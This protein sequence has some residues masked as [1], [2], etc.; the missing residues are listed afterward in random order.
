VHVLYVSQENMS[1]AHTIFWAVEE[2]DIDSSVFFQELNRFL[3]DAT[4]LF[5][6]GTSIAEDVSNILMRFSQG[7]PYIP[8][9]GSYG[10]ILGDDDSQ[11]FRCSFD[12]ELLTEL[13]R[14]SYIHAEPEICDH[15]MI[16]HDEELIMEYYDFPKNEIAFNGS[17]PE[18]KIRAFADALQCTYKK[19]QE[20]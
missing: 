7:G 12:S 8:E 15:I 18:Y 2:A 17:L 13:E 9:H 19:K 4:T 11:Y 10:S 16:Y 1:T 5:V 6:E 20:G 3:P 14:L